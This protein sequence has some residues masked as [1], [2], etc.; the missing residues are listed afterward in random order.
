MV[1]EERKKLE[2][3]IATSDDAEAIAALHALSWQRHY[4]GIYPDS[5]L[6]SE[7]IEERR[8]VWKK[9]LEHPNAN[10]FVIKALDQG[11]LIGFACTF[12]NADDPHGALVDNLHVLREYQG[13]GL[14][15][16]LLGICAGWVLEQRPDIPIYLYVLKENRAASEF[17]RYLGA[18]MSPILHYKGP[19]G[20][21]DEVIRCSWDPASLLPSQSESSLSS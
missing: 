8:S 18:R 21:D 2:F 5:Y 10:Q 16:K 4:R 17:Y 20:Q 19:T 12:I 9:R 6:D 15:K 1:F 3:S 11:T 14:G 7:V 13:K